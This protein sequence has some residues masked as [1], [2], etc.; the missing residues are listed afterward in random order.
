MGACVDR[1]D[2]SVGELTELAS[3]K[4][5]L[6]VE[7][8]ADDDLITTL[9]D[10]AKQHADGFLNNPF[11]VLRAVI[12]VISA[13]VGDSV[14]VDGMTFRVAA[15]EPASRTQDVVLQDF[16]IGGTDMETAENLAE[17][18]N[19]QMYGALNVLAAQDGIEISLTWR[20]GRK[21]PVTL[22][23]VVSTLSCRARRTQTDIPEAVR[24]GVLRTIAWM[25]DQR[26]DGIA[27]EAVSGRGAT[28]YG[29][30]SLAEELW[31]PHR[32]MPGT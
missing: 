3:V 6:R 32:K 17:I 18:I 12:F 24:T 7:H 13:A 4:L 11:E 8:E 27:T 28:N 1:L 19:D 14:G 22:S 30:P 31:A 20:T 16:A 5:Y 23:Q 9:I 21:E 2:L 26:Q 15:E 25:Y 10:A 29:A